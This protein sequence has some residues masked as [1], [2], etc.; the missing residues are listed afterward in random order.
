MEGTL[1]EETQGWGSVLNV[2]D[3][4]WLMGAQRERLGD[5]GPGAA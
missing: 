2:G 5:G 4:R 1:E 3:L